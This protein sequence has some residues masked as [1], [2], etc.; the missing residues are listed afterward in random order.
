MSEM[1]RHGYVY[2]LRCDGTM[3]HHFKLSVERKEDLSCSVMLSDMDDI[4]GFV[5]FRERTPVA[6]PYCK[7]LCHFTG[8]QAEYNLNI[9]EGVSHA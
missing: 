7:A 3:Q 1:C 6:C 9:K 5:V 4:T 2:L 8:L